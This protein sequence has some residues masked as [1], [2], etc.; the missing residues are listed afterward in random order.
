[1][2]NGKGQGFSLDAV[3]AV[4]LLMAALGVVTGLRSHADAGN[5][6]GLL[7]DDALAVLDVR[8]NLSSLNAATISAALNATLPSRAALSLSIS[9][10]DNTTIAIGTVGTDRPIGAGVR[11]FATP[12]TYCRA[13]H[14]TWLR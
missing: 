3:L 5:G 6:L 12:T 11:F 2:S 13:Q 10:A 8:G 7:G 4:I 9:C 1:V 14:R